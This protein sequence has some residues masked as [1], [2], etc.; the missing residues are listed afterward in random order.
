MNRHECTPSIIT[1]EIE[2]LALQIIQDPQLKFIDV[3]PR[4]FSKMNECFHNVDYVVRRM[5]W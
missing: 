5:R 4:Q 3:K 2:K 1:P